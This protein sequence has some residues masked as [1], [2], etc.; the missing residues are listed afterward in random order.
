MTD[1]DGKEIVVK[2]AGKELELL[3]PYKEI[4]KGGKQTTVKLTVR[5]KRELEGLLIGMVK[6]GDITKEQADKIKERATN[7]NDKPVLHTQT[8]ISTDAFPSII[9]SAVDFYVDRTQDIATVQHLIPY[10]TQNPKCDCREVLFLHHFKTL[11]YSY[12]KE[13][14]THM[15]HTEGSKET[16]LLYAMME[17]YSIYIYIVVLDN[18]YHGQDI[19]MTYTWD[20]VGSSEIE[21][22]FSLH[23]KMK[24]LLDFRNQ[25]H[26][27]YL[28]Y[29]PFV[30][31]R[32]DNVM[33]IWQHNNEREELHNVLENA[34]S[35][36]PK[37]KTFD[38]NDI[39]IIKQDIMNYVMRKINNSEKLN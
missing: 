1:N 9:K 11:P 26:N 8:S 37:G 28:S 27:Q 2:E 15:V 16:G 25:P 22:N 38:E 29:L 30:K 12:N 4:E 36:I 19:N 23:L 31:Q 14:V 24:D 32:A 34:F 5:N 18:K 21:R 20:V 17:Y 6:S 7:V 3:H 13:H 39:A 10:I 35:K 33:R